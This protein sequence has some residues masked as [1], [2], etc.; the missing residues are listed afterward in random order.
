M[1]VLH[2]FYFDPLICKTSFVPAFTEKP[3]I[4]KKFRRRNNYDIRKVLLFHEFHTFLSLHYQTY[5]QMSIYFT[6]YSHSL[7]NL[8]VL[9]TPF[10][11]SPFYAHTLCFNA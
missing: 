4:I 5:Q 11:L 6:L 8:V 7:K 9:I 3:P 1:I 2:E 10:D